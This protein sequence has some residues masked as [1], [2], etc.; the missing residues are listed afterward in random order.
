VQTYAVETNTHRVGDRD[1]LLRGLADRQQYSDPQGEAAK[2]GIGDANWSLFGVLWPSSSVL[3][4]L[5]HAIAIKERT[6][7]E[8]GCGLA[9]PSLILQSR[10]ADVSA[11]DYHPRAGEFLARNAMLNTL[12]AIPFFRSNWNHH[13]VQLGHFDVLFGGDILY[14][15]GHPDLIARFVGEHANAQSEVII[16]DPGRGRVNALTRLLASDGFDCSE[17]RT[18]FA[19]EE[20]KPF[21]GRVLTYSR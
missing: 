6:F 2:E 15:R 14:E 18:A 3:A 20:S 12:A 19:P 8:M 9:F 4:H 17:V 7:L 13:D 5:M 16:A 10:G 11:T 21:R 1:F